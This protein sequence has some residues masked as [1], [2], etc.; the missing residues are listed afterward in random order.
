MRCLEFL[1]CLLHFMEQL[2]AEG[3]FLGKVCVQ[4]PAC[5]RA[6][7]HTQMVPAVHASNMSVCVHVCTG[8][9]S[10]FMAA[11]EN[12][13]HPKMYLNWC[14]PVVFGTHRHPRAHTRILK[15]MTSFPAPTLHPRLPGTH[16][17]NSGFP[18]CPGAGHDQAVV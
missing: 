14:L 9:D 2:S 10:S 4:R 15:F 11:L 13:L 16:T 8:K 3:S 5:A 6:H 1:G 17:L 12:F 7:T 18:R